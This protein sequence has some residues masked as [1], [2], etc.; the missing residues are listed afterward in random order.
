MS[1]VS[2]SNSDFVSAPPARTNGDAFSWGILGTGAIA[3]KFAADLL[4]AGHSVLAAGSRTEESAVQFSDRHGIPRSYGTYGE[5]A[6]DPDIDAIYIATPNPLHADHARLAL[7]AGKHVLVEKPFALHPAD[8]HHVIEKA[9]ASGLIAME[10]MWTRF[11]P[12]WMRIK[13]LIHAGTIGTVTAII[14]DVSLPLSKDPQN[15]VNNPALGGGALMDLGVYGISLAIELLGSPESIKSSC[16]VTETKVDAQTSVILDFKGGRQALVHAS[17][18]LPGPQT[19]SIIGTDGRIDVSET[20]FRPS[21]F[22]VTTRESKLLVP[23]EHE[24]TYG[25]QYE[26][27]EIERLARHG[28]M[29]SAIMPHSQTL[30]TLA[31]IDH[32]LRQAGIIYEGTND[33]RSL[34]QETAN[35]EGRG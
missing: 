4:Y 13:D 30:Q 14:I 20:W 17:I 26:A 9:R 7:G 22:T 28:L 25:L 1:C 27:A 31:V 23:Y 18:D 10:A 35:L 33:V 11:L 24:P 3:N 34:F 2:S 32:V 6:A 19:T 8:A 15:R 16:R 12:N 21:D 5:L 29:E